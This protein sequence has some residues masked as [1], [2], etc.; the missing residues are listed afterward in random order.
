[1]KL[2]SLPWMSACILRAA[3]QAGVFSMVGE[4]PKCSGRPAW[5]SENPLEVTARKSTG[6]K[7][8]SDFFFSLILDPPPVRMLLQ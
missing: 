8:F 7:A 1:M 4:F 3:K 5:H 2:R 6:R